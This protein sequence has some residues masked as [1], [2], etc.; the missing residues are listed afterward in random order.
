MN[1]QTAAEK[2]KSKWGSMQTRSSPRFKDSCTQDSSEIT[3][4]AHTSTAARRT[5]IKRG[6]NDKVC[7]RIVLELH[8]C[9]FAP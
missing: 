6:V 9:L 8:V 7:K 1:P 2:L 3:P 4:V 5:K